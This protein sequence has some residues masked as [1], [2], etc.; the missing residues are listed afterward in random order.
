[1]MTYLEPLPNPVSSATIPV[2]QDYESQ[3]ASHIERIHLELA[4]IL[5]NEDQ[6][7]YTQRL[8][9]AL[10]YG[11]L[12]GGKR[13]RG[14]LAIESGLACGGELAHLLPTACAIELVHAQSLIHDDLPC[15]DDDDMRRGKPTVHRAFDEA[16][17]V[18]A[19][20]ALLAM[21]F[22]VISRDTAKTA[23]ITA[24]ILLAVMQDLSEV[25]SVKGLVNGQYVDIML[26]GKIFTQEAL[27]Y[28]HTFKTG[29]LFSF[30]LR[31][32]ARLAG[33][34]PERVQT[35]SLLGQKLGLAFQIIDDLL[36]IQS[37]VEA[38]GKTP[39]KDYL[40]K[41]ATYPALMGVERAREAAEKLVKESQAILESLGNCE[42]P[43][44]PEQLKGL[45][46]LSRF[47]CER[48]S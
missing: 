35:F 25:A 11:T 12:N 31:S 26:E 18:L 23:P 37:T 10:Q 32:G 34:S 9:Q 3:F 21:S 2:G 29:A 4:R 17:A 44:A 24:D 14:I 22:G 6:V 40:Q 47:I 20:D 15:M 39:G 7:P 38:L 45:Q 33:A 16:T 30:S 48:I 27:D 5:A 43:L 46:S 41:K 42:N 1:M 8:W 36:D 19:G 28:I 13:I